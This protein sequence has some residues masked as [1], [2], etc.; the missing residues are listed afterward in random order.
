MTDAA[1][2]RI[3]MIGLANVEDLPPGAAHTEIARW[4]ATS[5]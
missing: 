2:A 4:I 5:G 1:A 3:A